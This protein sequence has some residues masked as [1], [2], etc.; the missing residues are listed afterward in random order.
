VFLNPDSGDV[1]I[2]DNDNVR[3]NQQ[4]VSGVLGT[5][6]FMAPEIVRGEARPSTQTDLFSLSVL[7][8]YLFMLHHPLE[9]LKESSIHCFDLPAQ[10]K[11]YGTDPVFIFD[12]ENDSNRPDP[13]YHT[14]VLQR[15]PVYPACFTDLFVKAFTKGLSDPSHGRVRESEWRIAM[16]QLRDSIVYGPTGAE[17]FYCE[18]YQAEHGG[19]LRPCWATGKE[20]SPPLRLEIGR[21]MIVLN[22]DTK[23]YPHHVDDQR[24]WD[25]ETPAA[26]ITQH[27]SDPRVW[28]LKNLSGEKWVVRLPAGD[29]RNVKLVVGTKISFGR[30]EGVLVQ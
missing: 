28:G 19:K 3:V 11:L 23:L 24:R 29:T 25:F 8:F 22:R 21:S 18:K 20:I 26:E 27:P 12:P 5:P 7:L 13:K 14:C 2:C 10:R 17:N 4:V 16:A 30:A 6:R 1:L 15:W 9:G